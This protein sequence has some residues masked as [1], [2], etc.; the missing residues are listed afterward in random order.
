MA[1]FAQQ[2]V[3]V[4]GAGSG[5]GRA[6]A[7]AFVKE[8][9]YVIGVDLG[10]AS[11]KETAQLI[12]DAGGECETHVADVSDQVA[13]TALAQKVH[14][15]HGALDVLVNNAG[16]GASGRFLETSIETWDKV[17]AVNVRGVML[18]CKLFLPPMVERGRGHVVNTASM[19]GYFSAP[20][21]PI[22]AASKYAVLGFSEALRMDLKSKGIGVSAICPG[23]VNT[24]IVSTT[25]SEGEAAKWQ[26]G[27]VAFYKKRNYGPEKVADAI[28]KAVQH[29]RAV[30]PVSPEAWV[31]YYLKRFAPGLAR[32]LSASPLPF[33]K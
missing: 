32:T 5:I 14:A 17:H 22:Y 2:K 25:V 24:N 3:L 33:M 20:D 13:M 31:G 11:L 26:A 4:T 15:K 6:T 27:A 9:A 28:L 18:G 16:I 7:L 10:K 23:I 29:N 30:V 8:G 19:A 21:L 1:R 12:A